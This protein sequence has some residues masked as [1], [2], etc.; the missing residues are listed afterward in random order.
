M[1][2]NN[3]GILKRIEINL[4]N[5]CKESKLKRWETFRYAAFSP[6]VQTMSYFNNFIEWNKHFFVERKMRYFPTHNAYN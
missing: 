4:N 3:S 6:S 5:I 1:N 2:E